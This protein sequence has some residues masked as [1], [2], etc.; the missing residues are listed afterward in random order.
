MSLRKKILSV[1]YP[2]NET[3]EDEY[4]DRQ[5]ALMTAPLTGALILGSLCTWGLV[6][7][8][9]LRSQATP[10]IWLMALIFQSWLLFCLYALKSSKKIRYLTA[11]L[12]PIIP[13]ALTFTFEYYVVPAYPTKEMMIQ[14]QSLPLIMMLC[15]YAFETVTLKLPLTSGLLIS[16]VMFF[17]ISNGMKNIGIDFF[18]LSVQIMISNIA[19]ILMCIYGCYTA[20]AQFK[21]SRAAEKE[22]EVSDSLIKRVFPD[23]IG[24]ELRSRGS[25]VARTYQNVTVLL[26]DL[27]NFTRITKTMDPK[28]LVTILH[29]L[30]Q[31]FDRLAD[32]HGVEKIK[33]IGDAYMAAT[34]CP[35]LSASHAQRMGHFALELQSAMRSFNQTHKTEFQIR[36]GINSGSVVGG[37]ISGKR[38]SFDIWGETV[39]LASRLQTVAEPEEII[40]GE[41]T[42]KLLR[43]DFFISDFRVLD[44]KGLGS[45]PLARLISSQVKNPF[46]HNQPRAGGADSAEE[47]AFLSQH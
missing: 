13:T 19:G 11:Y 31:K 29:E 8:I 37:V 43:G 47:L 33:T 6:F 7:G 40:I 15:F 24:Q 23:I 12:T 27:A 39:N 28:Q 4:V 3:L 5:L 25:N 17:S 42:T 26:A 30:F 36:I 2:L 14:A 21:S 45:T 35:T 22:R 41:S 20:R 34:G 1:L 10:A 16:S 32:Q 18:Y 38:I 9:W 46:L 44:L